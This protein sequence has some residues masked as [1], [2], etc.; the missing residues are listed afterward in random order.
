MKLQSNSFVYGAAIP[1]EFAFAVVAPSSHV[2]FSTNRNPHLA[3]SDVPA[4]TRSFALVCH[5]PDVPSRGDDVNED[6]REVPVSLPRVDFYHWILL[7][8]PAT[9][10]EL[11][12][13]SHSEG[14]TL[15]G[16]SG[17]TA[18]GALRHGINDYTG[19]FAED[20]EMAGDYYG[21]DGPCPPWNDA[22][23]HHYVF[24]IY[25]LDVQSL[26]VRG[27]LTGANVSVALKGHVLASASLTGTY[28]LNPRLA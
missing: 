3:W 7:D 1:G 25:A 5:D 24:T 26:D 17:P 13:G 23:L 11:V 16:K 22:L 12:A 18:P 15:R 2:S 28:T 8:L 10:H 9:T 6:G 21:Y 19:W 27:P 20:C 14:V 4:G